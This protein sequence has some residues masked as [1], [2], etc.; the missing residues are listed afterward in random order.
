M[1]VFY[2]INRVCFSKECVYC[3]CDPSVHLDFLSMGFAYDCVC[4][5]F[6]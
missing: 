1:E 4:N 5:L 3:V 6:I 2:W